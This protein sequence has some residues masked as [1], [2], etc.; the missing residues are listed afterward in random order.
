MSDIDRIKGNLQ[1]MLGKGAPESDIDSYLKTEGHTPDSFKAA[2][3]GPP[4]TPG[5]KAAIGVQGFTDELANIAGAPVDAIAW[6]ARQA[7]VPVNEPVLGS[8]H[9][10]QGL[11]TIK[12][13]GKRLFGMTDAETRP[14]AETRGEKVVEGV[15]R[16][17]GGVA[18][19]L[20]PLGAL[21]NSGRLAGT[22]SAV[23][24][25]MRSAP[26]TQALA[27]ATGGAVTGATDNPWLGLAASLAVPTGMQ[28]ALRSVSAVPAAAG[29]A[30]AERRA[31]LETARTN[32][33][34]VSTGKI[35][36]SNFLQNIESM[37]GG[38]PIVGAPRQAFEERSR[39]A[40]NQAALR[41]AGEN[42]TAATPNT[43]EG[44]F[45]RVGA[46]FTNLTQGH[47]IQIRPQFA[48]AMQTIRN[49]Y[50]DK[51][52]SQIRPGIMRQIDELTGAGAAAQ[53]PGQAVILN[54]TTYQRIRSDLS[55]LSGEHADGDVRRA[56]RQMVN[57]L[58]DE[59]GASLPRDVMADWQTARRQWR[60]LSTINEAV[61]ARNNP[62]TATG[63]IPPAALASRSQTNPDLRDISR[64][65]TAFIGDKVPN[66]GTPSRL[67]A[68]GSLGG[69]GGLIQGGGNPMTGA[70][71]AAAAGGVPLASD[72]LLN[73]PAT[74]ALLM[75]RYRNATQ[76]LPVGGLVSSL[77]AQDALGR[78]R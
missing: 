50:G 66:S 40:F 32:D 59:A 5:R 13:G 29:S 74:R 58:D 33:I 34:P 35:T 70:L 53:Q 28:T 42:A 57:A 68:L 38:L 8:A 15:G 27:G 52:L 25:T 49:E 39:G 23:V 36:N 18:G 45:Q 7:G 12:E 37:I 64:V 24:D 20:A 77:A 2:V 73:N 69:I 44:S 26:A 54:G 19:M 55:K 61:L 46:V 16:G 1:I 71:A 51:L 78:D 30:E 62:S 67:L 17:L 6:G 65:G 47:D 60:N 22:P 56:A 75:S 63:N 14:T 48:T 4:S 21:A 3:T 31:L 76:G 72:L 10:K 11:D 43:M 9:L 41:T